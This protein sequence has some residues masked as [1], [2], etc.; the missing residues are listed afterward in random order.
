M[1]ERWSYCTSEMQGGAAQ[2]LKGLRKEILQLTYACGY[3]HPCQFTGKDIEISSGVN[4]FEP[5]EKI[6]GYEKVKVPMANS[7]N[8]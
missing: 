1:S 4:I 6:I 7:E 2:Y 3:T 5:L 8:I